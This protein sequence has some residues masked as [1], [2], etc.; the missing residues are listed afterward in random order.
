MK[1][2]SKKQRKAAKK[3]FKKLPHNTRPFSKTDYDNLPKELLNQRG[4]SDDK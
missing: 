4:S 2:T 3:L 1:A